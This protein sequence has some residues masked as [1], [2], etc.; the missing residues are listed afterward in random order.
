MLIDWD[1]GSLLHEQ[2]S[3]DFLSEQAMMW[4][5]TLMDVGGHNEIIYGSVSIRALKCGVQP[6]ETFRTIFRIQFLEDTAS[7]IG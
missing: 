2:P 5:V 7:V 3:Q 1:W 6:G 4:D